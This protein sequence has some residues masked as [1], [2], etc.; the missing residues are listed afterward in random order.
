MKIYTEKEEKS[1]KFYGMGDYGQ[2]NEREIAIICGNYSGQTGALISQ[3]SQ[4]RGQG[5]I[6][7]RASDW[8]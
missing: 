8:R 4:Q 1:A 5:M 7:V 2:E 3:G 6:P